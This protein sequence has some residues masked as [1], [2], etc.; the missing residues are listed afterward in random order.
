MLGW[1][2][3]GS[4]DWI[5]FD[6]RMIQFLDFSCKHLDRSPEQERE[7]SWFWEGVG[8]VRSGLF[9]PIPTDTAKAVRAV[10]GSGNFY[11]ITGEQANLLF[12][13]ILL[14]DPARRFQK[15]VRILADLYLITI[16]QYLE[17]LPDFQ[18]ADA[19]RDRRDWKYALH[20]PLNVTGFQ[21]SMFCDFRKL[22][23][24]DQASLQIMQTLLS[25][26][27][28]IGAPL[29]GGFLN[30]DAGQIV[31]RV[32]L[33]SRLASIWEAISRALEAL[34]IKRP[35]WLRAISLPH[36]YERY[37]YSR[38]NLN[39]RA[40][41]HELEKLAQAIGY[42]GFYLLKAI[43]GEGELADLPEVASLRHILEEHYKQVEGEVL[44]RK[45]TCAT[46]SVISSSFNPLE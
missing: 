27:S 5:P 31:A 23:L 38:G 7:G 46:C 37:S 43:A 14:D 29:N 12:S 11:M 13:G 22:L 17:T 26:F 6:P 18:A 32:C 42:D 28:G 21:A 40:V 4:G 36:W 25:R 39:L 16:F 8:S 1:L 10:F 20:L 24:A 34:A 3:P 33:F 2:V 30:L 15:P 44:W 19:V 35:D 9:P 45:D 41:S